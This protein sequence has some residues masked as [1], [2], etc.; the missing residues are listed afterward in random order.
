[1]KDIP[2]IEEIFSQRPFSIR[3]FV[4]DHK[5]G[6]LGTI[7]FHLLVLIILLLFKIQSYK[8][9]RDLDLA[10][11]YLESPEQDPS[12]EELQEDREVLLTRLFEQQLRLSNR[13]VNISKLE[14]E[15]S[16]ENYVEEVMKDLEQE[17]TEEWLKQQENIE[18]ILNKEDIIP[19]EPEIEKEEQPEFQGPTNISYEFLAAPYNRKSLRLPIPVYKCRGFGVVEVSI[20][21]NPSGE[22]TSAKAKV[23]EATQDPECLAEV[24]QRFALQSIFRG[25]FSAPASHAGK[26]TYSFVAQ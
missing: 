21:V 2:E 10:I 25:D 7:A 15:I 9:I 26:I 23:I 22:V 11:E 20:T 24:A 5:V 19:V 16:T 14:E 1:M 8:E 18:N 17:R 3:R 13:A 12:E 6:I 4:Q